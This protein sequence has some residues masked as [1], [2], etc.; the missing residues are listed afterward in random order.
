M[1]KLYDIAVVGAGVAGVAA[2]T[3]LALDGH[4]VLLLASHAHHPREFRAEKFGAYEAKLLDRLGLWEASRSAMTCFD[5]VL[6]GKWGQPV[7]RIAMQEYSTRYPDFVDALRNDAPDRID[8]EIGR[9]ARIEAGVRGQELVMADDS[10]RYAR[11]VVLATGLMD[12][13]RRELGMGKTTIS[14]AHSLVFGFDVAAGHAH[15]PFQSLTWQGERFG[16]GIAYLTL[17][18]LDRAM[19]VNLFTHW[20]PA[21]IDAAAFV[22]DPAGEVASRLPGFSRL[23]GRFL[24]DGLVE[25]RSIDLVAVEN[26]KLDGVVVIGDAFCTSCPSTGTGIR[27]VLTD[28]DRLAAHAQRWLA[29]PGMTAAKIASFYADP[30]KTACDRDSL[31]R[32]LSGRCMLV[33]RSVAWRFRRLRSYVYRRGRHELGRLGFKSVLTRVPGGA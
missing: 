29:T 22:R 16:D 1:R 31:A 9:V 11:L 26:H 12:G 23:Y 17:F 15:V 19:R 3:R 5:E 24:V 7:G 21:G 33:D 32:S 14:R 30:V 27:K 2:A 6:L 25:Q 28:V 13:L 10:R 18:P 4:A 20:E 8:H